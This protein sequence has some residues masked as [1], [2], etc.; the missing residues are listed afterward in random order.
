MTNEARIEAL[1]QSIYIARNNR[2]NAVT[3]PNLLSFLDTTIEWVNQFT[4]EIEKKAD[5]NFVRI[6][7]NEIGNI[8]DASSVSYALP[9]EVRKLVVSPY[10]SLH[11]YHDTSSIASFKVVSPDLL[12]RAGDIHDLRSRVTTIGRNIVFSRQMTENELGS[13]I[14]ADTIQFIPKLSLTDVS[15]LDLLDEYPDIRQLYVLGIVKNQILP[16]IVQGGL[17]PSYSQKFDSYLAECI[18]EN[19]AS[20]DSADADRESFS[21][22]GGV[23]M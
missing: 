19:D 6:N 3:G 17:T 20:A 1:A 23:G 8:F 18:R 7:D 4:P 22:V 14:F 21:W 10:R 11:L 12:G 5:W 9:E 13:N 15:L 2:K 16:D